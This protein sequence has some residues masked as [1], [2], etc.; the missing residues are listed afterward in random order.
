MKMYDETPRFGPYTNRTMLAAEVAASA[1][2]FTQTGYGNSEQERSE[3]LLRL[4]IEN[5]GEESEL[6]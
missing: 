3:Q 5:G 2:G 4:P 1:V 6:S